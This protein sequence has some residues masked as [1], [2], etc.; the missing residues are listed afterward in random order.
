MIIN[1]KKIEILLLCW[2]LWSMMIMHQKKTDLKSPWH[3]F[4][5]RVSRRWRRAWSWRT[6]SSLTDVCPTRWG[7]F[8]WAFFD[9]S[10]WRCPFW[11]GLVVTYSSM[12][13][14]WDFHV[15]GG[16]IEVKRQISYFWWNSKMSDVGAG[17]VWLQNRPQNLKWIPYF[18]KWICSTIKSI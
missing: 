11:S 4:R 5:R 13:V 9:W 8:C 6:N 12:R 1:H 10:H 14:P 3:P 18:Q 15:G 7:P 17:C 2:S 16:W